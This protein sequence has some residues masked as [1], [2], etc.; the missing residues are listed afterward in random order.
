M[1]RQTVTTLALATV[2]AAGGSTDAMGQGKPNPCAAK[3]PCGAKGQSL[4]RQE[5][6]RGEEPVCRQEP[7][8]RPEPVREEDGRRRDQGQGGGGRLQGVQELEASTTSP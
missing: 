5:S 4:W 1:I 8:R 7:L 3:N 6:L 2:L